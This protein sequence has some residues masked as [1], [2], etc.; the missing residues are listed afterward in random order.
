MSERKAV[1]LALVLLTLATT[2]VCATVMALGGGNELVVLTTV[3]ILGLGVD[4]ISKLIMS[5]DGPERR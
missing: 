1:T 2:L 3:V 5:F 4:Q